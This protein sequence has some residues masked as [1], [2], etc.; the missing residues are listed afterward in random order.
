VLRRAALATGAA[1]V[2]GFV[3]LAATI[4]APESPEG[5]IL[6]A[7]TEATTQYALLALAALAV[8]VG[9]RAPAV[10]GGLLVLAATGL[11]VLAALEYNPLVAVVPFLVLFAPGLALLLS[12]DHARTPRRSTV[13]AAVAVAI[14]LA[15]GFGALRVH[16]AA[17]GPTH[18]ESATPQLPVTVVRW[19]WAGG[20]TGESFRVVAKLAWD[21]DARLLVSDRRDL[22]AAI[23]TAPQRASHD[24]ND[25]IVAFEVTGLAADRVYYYAVESRGSIDRARTGRVRTFARG[26]ASFTFAFGGCARVGSNGAVFDAIRARNPLFFLLLGDFFYA[27]IDEDDE[28]AFR[29]QYDRALTQPAQAALYRS[30]PVT[31]VWDDHDFGPNDADS[32][33]ASA[34]A[35]RAA[36]ERLVPHY[37]LPDSRAVYHAFTVGRVRFI[38]TDTR[39]ARTTASMLGARQERWLRREL[40]G[41]KRRGELAVWVNSVPWIAGSGGDNWSAYPSER[42]ALADFVAQREIRNLLM[43]SGDAHMVAID[44]GT[45]ND[46]A[47]AGDGSFPVM[48]AA[49]LDRRGDVKGGPFSEGVF[50]GSGQ[51]GTVTVTDDG[52]AR[53]TVRLTG[54]N[55]RGERLVEHAF[56]RTLGDPR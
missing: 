4:G 56:T 13:I 27:N 30:A 51:F 26:P 46:Y 32:S 14:L 20:V 25:R 24:D 50:P 43:L 16:A 35:A 38:V 2:T 23:A 42:R 47:S 41:A 49:A 33:A 53:V 15:G 52:G 31:Y 34:P 36:Y 55:H 11:G 40:L 37:R 1:T 48:H 54:W 29:N 28:E 5:G 18:P 44:D 8:V 12:S 39:A 3:A 6:P 21:G 17:F 9:L 19:A 7:A 22:S 45:N 10:A